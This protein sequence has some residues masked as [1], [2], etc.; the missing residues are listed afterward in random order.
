[1]MGSIESSAMSNSGQFALDGE[2]PWSASVHKQYTSPWDTYSFFKIPAVIIDSHH[3]LLPHYSLDTSLENIFIKT[4]STWKNR[5]D[6]YDVDEIWT[7]KVNTVYN[8]TILHVKDEIKMS[9]SVQ[10]I[11]LPEHSMPSDGNC[12]AIGFGDDSNRLEE[13]KVKKVESS[14][15][16]KHFSYSGNNT[17]CVN[18]KHDDPPGCSFYGGVSLDVSCYVFENS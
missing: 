3:V 18:D 1:M 11:C 16:K 2:W 12:F 17:F 15:C 6:E 13:K 5:G 7:K 10:P 9:R 4:G 8:I 14:I